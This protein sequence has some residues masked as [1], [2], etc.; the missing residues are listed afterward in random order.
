MGIKER[1]GNKG[2]SAMPNTAEEDRIAA[3]E[4]MRVEVSDDAD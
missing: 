3:I 1:N 4:T 2:R